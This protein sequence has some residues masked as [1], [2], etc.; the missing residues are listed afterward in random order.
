MVLHAYW[1]TSGQTKSLETSY[2][3][4]NV[5]S[6]SALVTYD[7]DGNLN[8]TT[9]TG[10]TEDGSSIFAYQ[11]KCVAGQTL[12]QLANSTSYLNWGTTYWD[13]EQSL[14]RLKWTLPTE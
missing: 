8:R 12:S 9:K 13:Y 6:T 3:H 2:Q 5:S 1:G 4:D 14:P 7:K 11:G 10:L